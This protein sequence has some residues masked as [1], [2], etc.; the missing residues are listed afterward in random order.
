MRTLA[1]CIAS[2]FVAVATATADVPRVINY[3]GKL[4][5]ASG[6]PVSGVKSMTFEFYNAQT[7]GA[8]LGGFAESQSVAVTKGVFNVLIGSATVGGVPQGVFTGLDVYIS[9]NVEGEDLTPRQRVASVGFAFKAAKADDA[10]KLGGQDASVFATGSQIAPLQANIDAEEAARIA[11]DGAEASARAAVYTAL[12]ERVAALEALLAGV[13]L[14]GNTMVISGLNLQIVNGTGTTDGAVKGTGNLIVGYNEKRGD[15]T[16]DRS[17]SHN[18]VVGEKHNFTSY[19]GLVVG[20]NNTISGSY[21]SVSG[22]FNNTASKPWS[23]VCGGY[24][25]TA[26]GHYSS[27]SGGHGNTA[28]GNR[29]SVSGGVSNAASGYYSSVSGGYSNTASGYAASVAGGGGPDPADGNEAFADYSAILG[30]ASNIAGD[31]DLI[32]H[33]IGTQSTVSGGLENTA[34]GDHSSV[35]GGRFNTASGNYS[36]VSG[37]WY[38]DASGDHSSVSAGYSNEASGWDSSVSGGYENTASGKGSSVSGGWANAASG[39]RSSVSG[40]YL[41]EASGNRSSVSGGDS[42]SVVGMYDWRAGGLF[43]DN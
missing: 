20:D 4:T 38:H 7:G 37:G 2:V 16:D 13:S 10:D 1:I 28:S 23:S 41:N 8:L 40:G 30:G 14:N 12:S 39:D 27:V 42:R 25:N 6:A 35:S 26:S 3:Q 11:A 31:P 5:N 17:G 34:S 33:N 43:Q 21:A 15:A 22:G 32:D 19:G 24:E 36:S 18:I 29:S 9:V